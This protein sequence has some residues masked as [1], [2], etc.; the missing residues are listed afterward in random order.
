MSSNSTLPPGPRGKLLTTYRILAR[1]FTWFPRWRRRYGDPFT[2][3]A[4]NGTVVVTGEPDGIAQV[5]AARPDAFEVFAPR[6]VTP[7]VGDG[8][9]LVT[10]GP[11]HRRDRRLLAPTF[12]GARM[13][14]YGAT[15]QEV[16]RTYMCR[17]PR[18]ARFTAHRLGLDISLE[19]IVRA[20][21]GVSEAGRVQA[22]A[23]AAE[24]LIRA[25][26]PL[27]LFF[28]AL[29]RDFYGFG[30]WARFRRRLAAF[31]RLLLE[32]VERT[33]PVA[34]DPGR[35]DVL[36]RILCA[37]Y[38]DGEAP[39]DAE[40]LAHL[41][42]LLSAGHETTAIALAWALYWVHRTPGVLERLRAELAPLG[43]VPDPAAL[44]RLP[45]LEAVIQETLRIYPLVTEV[46]RVT[47]EPFELLGRV[48]PPGVAVSPSVLLAHW[49]EETFPEPQRFRPERFLG[50]RYG[51]A[52][53]L[54]FG[55][56]ARRCLGAA[57]AM[58]ELKV[59]LGTVLAGWELELEDR[60]VRPV[61]RNVTMAPRG[62]VR[63]TVKARSAPSAPV[64]REAVAQLAV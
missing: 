19:V 34:A 45:Y 42:T 28:P 14:A 55:G 63:L 15:V 27:A 22:V 64:R 46:L 33:R 6:A 43:P 54:P 38:E 51:P 36:S 4:V 2:L 52:E 18:G 58:F 7:L 57:F 10:S 12:N 9:V 30:P 21:F 53:F 39:S 40:V 32:Q 16:T 31:D 44:E 37:R 11:R 47:K 41:R 17:R 60:E 35:E 50:R 25:V 5:F 62:G 48:L 8:S 24:G 59:A 61:R 13:R 49:R 20:V 29:Q 26:S 3:H 56:G 1:P 23:R